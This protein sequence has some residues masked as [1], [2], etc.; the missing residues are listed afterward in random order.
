M[1]DRISS[2]DLERGP[3]DIESYNRFVQLC[4]E[5]VILTERLGEADV[6]YEGTGVPMI[7]R[8]LAGRKGK[9]SDGSAKTREAK[10]LAGLIQSG[11]LLEYWECRVAQKPTFM[12]QAPAH[13]A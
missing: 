1:Q 13:N 2:A 5:F 4:R 7:P 6:C 3:K 8:E 11:R 12:S 9:Q 10:A